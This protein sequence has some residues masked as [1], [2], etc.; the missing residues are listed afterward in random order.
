MRISISNIAW[1]VEKDESIADILNLNNVDAIDVAPSK[2]LKDFPAIDINSIISIRNWW[3]KRG[4]EIIGMQSLLYGVKNIALFESSIY[5]NNMKIVLEKVIKIGHLFGAKKLVF[6]SP[7]NR[8]RN[9]LKQ[10]VINNISS[11]FFRFVGDISSKY[12]IIFCIEP[13]PKEYG[14][15]FINT[16]SEAL[17]L[18]QRIDHPN[19]KMQLDTG[20]LYFSRE[21]INEIIPIASNHIGHIHISEPYLKKICSQNLKHSNIRKSLLGIN[22]SEPITIEMLTSSAK[23]SLNEIEESIN[24]VVKKYRQQ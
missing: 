2:Y 23:S 21:S 8:L 9:D 16:T 3:E 22:Y 19:I 13:N 5:R 6:G 12:G 20:S 7:K 11:D 10:E 4:I 24:F 1:E 15:D 17:E 18:V 14:C